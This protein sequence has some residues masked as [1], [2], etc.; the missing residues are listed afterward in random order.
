MST[1]R[2]SYRPLT[3][4]QVIRRARKTLRETPEDRK[5]DMMVEIGLLTPDQAAR[6]K[7]NLLEM[8]EQT[9]AEVEPASANSAPPADGA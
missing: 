8:A 7:R 3:M 4:T 2:S 9:R 5:I 6:A 1:K